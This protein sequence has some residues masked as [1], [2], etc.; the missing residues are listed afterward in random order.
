MSRIT[1][2]W[3]FAMVPSDVLLAPISANAKLLFTLY[4][5][6]SSR[7]GELHPGN[8]RL[9]ELM[10]NVSPDTISRAKKELVKHEFIEVNAR[11]NEGRRTTDSIHLLCRTHADRIRTHADT[12]IRTGA[13]TEVDPEEREKA[14]APHR[15]P[16]AN[17]RPSTGEPNSD[18]H[19]QAETQTDPVD[20]RGF[21][22]LTDED[23]QRGKDR[24]H[25]IRER[26]FNA[27]ASTDG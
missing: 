9:G 24:L 12:G 6:Y 19:D 15:T 4:C 26:A 7:E 5:L 20:E 22:I 10:G 18:P 2:S 25:L 17:A 3:E 11:Y 14:F 16:A 1:K 23:R 13:A 27:E 21:P 8:R